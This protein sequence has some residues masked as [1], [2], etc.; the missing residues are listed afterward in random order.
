MNDKENKECD[1]DRE[2]KEGDY[3]EL[4]LFQELINI[5]TT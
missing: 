1:Q 5:T 3:N 4:P 2:G